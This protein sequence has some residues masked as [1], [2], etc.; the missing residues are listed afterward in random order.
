MM[1]EK[2]TPEIGGGSYVSALAGLPILVPD[3]S[4]PLLHE[5]L[6]SPLP[7]PPEIPIFIKVCSGPYLSGFIDCG[8]LVFWENILIACSTVA[9]I[10]IP[11]ERDTLHR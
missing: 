2:E 5:K 1:A 11:D 9:S 4:S 8:N 10:R 3:S 7:V 6:P